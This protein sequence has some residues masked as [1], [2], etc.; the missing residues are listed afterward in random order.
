MTSDFAV[1]VE[2]VLKLDKRGV[3]NLTIVRLLLT[4]AVGRA[5]MG[6]NIAL[7]RKIQEALGETLS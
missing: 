1:I 3:H 4:A 5:T 7:A 2:A 6:G